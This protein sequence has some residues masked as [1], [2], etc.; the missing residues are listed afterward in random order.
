MSS[1]TAGC[2]STRRTSPSPACSCRPTISG[3]RRSEAGRSRQPWNI[4]FEDLASSL[5]VDLG[6]W[7]WGAQFG[8]L[9]NDGTLDLY[10]VNGYVSAGERTQ[11]LVRLRADRRRSQRHHRR[12]AELAGDEGPKPVR[13]SAQARL[14]QRRPGPVHRCRA[15]RRRHRR[16]RRPGGRAC[17]SLESRRARRDRRQPARSAAASTRTPCSRAGTG[18]T[19][20]S[21]APRATAAR[22]ARGSRCTGTVRRRC[23][24]SAAASGFSAQNQRRASLRAGCRDGGRS[25]RRSAGRPAG[26]QTIEKPPVDR[27]H[28]IKEPNDGR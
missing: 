21:R 10:L 28:T 6:G 5:G 15:G 12:R 26:V 27:I 14:A 19:S 23:R 20:S 7:S 17:R 24:R 1:T 16:L 9:N 11:L 4:V 13:L 18:S 25:R 3:F 22:S 2:R 8:D